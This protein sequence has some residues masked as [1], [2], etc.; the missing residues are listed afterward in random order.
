MDRFWASLVSTPSKHPRQVP[1]QCICYISISSHFY[2][3][4]LLILFLLF[5][6]MHDESARMS[7]KRKSTTS[8]SW[9]HKLYMRRV[10]ANGQIGPRITYSWPWMGSMLAHSFC[11]RTTSS[12]SFDFFNHFNLTISIY[13]TFLQKHVYQ[14]LPLN[15]TCDRD[16][17]VLNFGVRLFEEAKRRLSRSHSHHAKGM[18]SVPQKTHRS[19]VNAVWT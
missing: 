3:L 6:I 15:P 18:V 10:Y 19:H 1:R 14:Q 13:P 9:T 2:T 4:A 17:S 7:K 12:E 11:C 8:A 5:L 16:R